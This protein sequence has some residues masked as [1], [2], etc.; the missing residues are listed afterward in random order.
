[1]EQHCH[2]ATDSGG[3]TMLSGLNYHNVYFKAKIREH[4]EFSTMN[5]Q[6]KVNFLTIL[7]ERSDLTVNNSLPNK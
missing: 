7:L 5:G 4:K 2:C 6:K 1:M 3:K